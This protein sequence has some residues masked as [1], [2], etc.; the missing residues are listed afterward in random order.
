RN[1]TRPNITDDP[2]A[3]ETTK[4]PNQPDVEQGE[5]A[6]APSPQSITPSPKT[7]SINYR[8]GRY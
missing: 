1:P 7:R 5:D 3:L 4:P 8:Y 6:H 2:L